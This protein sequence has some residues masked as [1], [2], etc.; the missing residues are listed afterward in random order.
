MRALALSGHE[1]QQDFHYVGP[2]ANKYHHKNTM[3]IISF[4][5]V[6]KYQR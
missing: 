1:C 3:P 5:T 6:W 2:Q 4:S